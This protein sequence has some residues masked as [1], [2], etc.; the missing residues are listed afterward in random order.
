MMI[1]TFN[2]NEMTFEE[3]M[4]WEENQKQKDAR[5]FDEESGEVLF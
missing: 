5:L 3:R 2:G 1:E 4:F